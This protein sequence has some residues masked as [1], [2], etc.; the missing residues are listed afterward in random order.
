MARKAPN[1]E[2]LELD[3]QPAPRV[4]YTD[5]LEIAKKAR[6]LK[7]RVEAEKK[8]GVSLQSMSAKQRARVGAK[9]NIIEFAWAGIGFSLRKS[10]I[11]SA[12]GT[13]RAIKEGLL[14]PFR[15]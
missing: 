3:S 1:K 15:N 7:V 9:K 2:Y 13:G 8:V 10:L 6:V 14:G 5:I 12:K 11:A 4:G